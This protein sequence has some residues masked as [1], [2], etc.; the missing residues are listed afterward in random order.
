MLYT[1]EKVVELERRLDARNL[2]QHLAHLGRLE[3]AAEHRGELV[4]ERSRHAHHRVVALLV[5]RLDVEEFYA[6]TAHN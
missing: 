5:L 1:L 2:G 6:T 4:R 3:H